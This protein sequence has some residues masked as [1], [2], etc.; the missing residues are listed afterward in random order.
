MMNKIKLNR[1]RNMIIDRARELLRCTIC[2]SP[3]NETNR[4][5]SPS[6]RCFFCKEAHH[7]VFCQAAGQSNHFMRATAADNTVA[8]FMCAIV[9]VCESNNPRHTVR[10]TMSWDTMSSKTFA[11]EAVC[12]AAGTGRGEPEATSNGRYQVALPWVKPIQE[13]PKKQG[14]AAGRLR[15]LLKSLRKSPDRLQI[16]EQII[17]TA[18]RLAG[19][20]ETVSDPL[21]VRG[22]LNYLPH[23][24][25]FKERKNTTKLMIV[26]DASS[27]CQEQLKTLNNCLHKGPLLLNDLCGVLLRFSIPPIA[28]VA[29]L[30]KAYLQ[31]GLLIYSR[32]QTSKKEYLF[33]NRII[34]SAFPPTYL[35][36][37]DWKDPDKFS[38]DSLQAC[39]A[40]DRKTSFGCSGACSSAPWPSCRCQSAFGQCGSSK[41]AAEF[42]SREDYAKARLYE[43]DHHWFGFVKSF[44]SIIQ[45]SIILLCYVS[46][47]L[48]QQTGQWSRGIISDGEIV[49]TIVYYMVWKLFF[50]LTDLPFSYYSTFVIEER[51]GFNRE[52]VPFF[53]KDQVKGF[54]VGVV[55]ELP[56]LLAKIAIVQNGGPYMVLFLWLISC[57][58]DFF[59]MTIYPIFIAPLF[60][61]CRTEV[62][63]EENFVVQGSKRSSHSNAYMYGFWNSKRIVLYDTLLSQEWNEK[64]K[65]IFEP[66]QYESSGSESG[67]EA[68][69]EISENQ[70]KGLS[71][72]E[73]MAVLH[74]EL[75]HWKLGHTLLDHL[76]SEIE[77]LMSFA[78]FALLYQYKPLYS[79]FGFEGQPIYIGMILIF[80]YVLAPYDEV[81]SIAMSF[82]SRWME[83]SADNFAA[84]MGCAKPLCSSLIKLDKDNLSLPVDDRLY[85]MINFSHP[86]LKDRVAALKKYK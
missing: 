12:G 60:D 70:D 31:I 6:L 20:I 35:A 18:Q 34:T 72:D 13:L 45:N 57:V 68:G 46:A 83:S 28:I 56:F 4:C 78:I 25:V 14:L 77:S 32:R 62:P 10:A 15:S 38:H 53:F 73:V 85:A 37:P 55:T 29:D 54:A 64:L 44:H 71:D 19:V 80:D 7:Q 81:S 74:H 49:H 1:L 86:A 17:K 24:V 8:V 82:F 58:V 41:E 22:P 2:L 21:V 48:W 50:A 11:T 66:D 61:N 26:Y 65:P 40:F 52:T 39:F 9:E 16:Y 79:A 33:S 3:A 84:E 27:K 59:L 67:S 51:H 63:A 43:L 23:Q 30:E 5:N 47:R 76:I 42:I 75:G 69:S 36:Q